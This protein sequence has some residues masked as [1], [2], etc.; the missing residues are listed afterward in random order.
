MDKDLLIGLTVGLAVAAA[1]GAAWYFTQKKP[2]PVSSSPAMVDS[3]VKSGSALTSGSDY[4]TRD[5]FKKV[6]GP[7]NQDVLNALKL[8]QEAE[9][10]RLRDLE[11]RGF[12]DRIAGVENQQALKVSE[13]DTINRNT[14][15]LNDFITACEREVTDSCN[16]SWDLFG[17][18]R[19][20]NVPKC[21]TAQPGDAEYP[22]SGQARLDRWRA[23]QRFPLE[24]KLKELEVQYAGMVNELQVRFSVTYNP[25]QPNAHARAAQV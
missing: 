20:A 4:G 23:E 16:K 11:I 14:G 6:D 25:S 24:Q 8:Q 7:S 12:Q 22:Y 2:G 17:A 10:R 13:I 1:G 19:N 15:P 3:G 9:Q 21:R 18:C 5:E